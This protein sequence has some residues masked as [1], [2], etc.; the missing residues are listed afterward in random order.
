MLTNCQPP[1]VED[2]PT[3]SKG[4]SKLRGADRCFV[5]GD[6]SRDCSP[7]ACAG[8]W[9]SKK[10]SSEASSDEEESSNGF[11]DLAEAIRFILQ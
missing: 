3:S 8:A 11:V 6:C 5:A 4:L 1:A 9:Q 10:L 2:V 7:L